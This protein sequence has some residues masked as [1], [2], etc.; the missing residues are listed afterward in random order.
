MSCHASFLIC[1][2]MP[3]RGMIAGEVLFHERPT[4]LSM[5][6]A[7]IIC[8]VTIGVTLYEN[9][10]QE[11]RNGSILDTELGATSEGLENRPLMSPEAMRP[12]VRSG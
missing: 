5:A 6:G 4:L 8:C 9:R 11:Q 10:N 3:A 1:L 12:T 2:G 7:L